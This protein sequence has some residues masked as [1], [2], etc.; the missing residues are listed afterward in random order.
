MGRFGLARHIFRDKRLLPRYSFATPESCLAA[1]S[2]R[3]ILVSLLFR[4]ARLLSRCSLAT[5]DSC[6]RCSFATLDSCLAALRFAGMPSFCT[7][8]LWGEISGDCS[9]FILWEEK[10]SF[11]LAFPIVCFSESRSCCSISSRFARSVTTESW[12]S[13]FGACGYLSSYFASGSSRSIYVLVSPWFNLFSSVES[14][15]RVFVSIHVKRRLRFLPPH[16]S[17]A[18]LHFIVSPFIGSYGASTAISWF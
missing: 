4:D 18:T 1:L 3:S 11:C 13:V 6:L 10:Q 14:V 8:S 9:T 5:L 15:A 2:R 12:F 16:N 7:I 17:W